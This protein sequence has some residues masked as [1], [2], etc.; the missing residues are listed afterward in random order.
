MSIIWN[1]SGRHWR[2]N[3]PDWILGDKSRMTA[4]VASYGFVLIL[5]LPIHVP[6][7]S[8]Q[9]H[10]P[11]A[12]RVEAVANPPHVMGEYVAQ[13]I[14]LPLFTEQRLPSGYREYRFE[15]DCGMCLPVYLIRIRV[16]PDRKILGD[17]YLLWFGYDSSLAGDTSK[18]ARRVN[19]PPE[20]CDSPLRNSSLHGP[21][22]NYRWCKARL[23][24]N[25]SW[26]RL[27]HSLDSLEILGL[28]MVKGYAPGPPNLGI[29]TVRQADRTLFIPRLDCRDIGSPSIELSALV[30]EEYRSAYFWCLESKA[31]GKPEHFRVAKAHEM[32]SNAVAAYRDSI[33]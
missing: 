23:A 7:A 5:A 6:P 25:L 26:S 18:R 21:G 10:W 12:A 14:G 31:P 9:D 24:T 16:P 32:L 3:K 4:N 8:A 29:D 17:A 15:V 28:P 13:I 27:L 22:G 1:R 30:G 20:N 2:T 19:N 11:Y 33:R